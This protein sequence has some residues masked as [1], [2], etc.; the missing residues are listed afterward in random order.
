MPIDGLE[1]LKNGGA[2]NVT[3][4]STSEP[5]EEWKLVGIIRHIPGKPISSK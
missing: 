5:P 2:I 4:A 1:G 3:G